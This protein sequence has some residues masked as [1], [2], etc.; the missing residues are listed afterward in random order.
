MRGNASMLAAVVIGVSFLFVPQVHATKVIVEK[1]AVQPPPGEPLVYQRVDTEALAALGATI[2]AEYPFYYLADVPPDSLGTFLNSAAAR[3]FVISSRES[4]DEIRI[5]GYAFPS[6][7]PLPKLPP[8]LTLADYAGS[9][10]LYLVQLVGPN[11]DDWERTLRAITTPILYYADNTYVLRADPKRLADLRAL[12]FLQHV[13]VFQ[14]A[15]KVRPDVLAAD[16]PV[17]VVVQL[18]GGQD[19]SG[20]T[21]ILTSLA[22]REVD[23]EP[24]GPIRNV[25]LTL[26]AGDATTLSFLPEVVWI[27]RLWPGEP[28]DERQALVVAGQHNGFQPINPATYTNWL[29]AK[30]FCT[31]GSSPPGCWSYD[32]RVAVFDSGFDIH[33]CGSDGSACPGGTE[34]PD[35]IP[36]EDRFFCATTEP[37]VCPE[38]WLTSNCCYN[39]SQYVNTDG[40][41]HGTAVA[42]VIAGDTSTGRRSAGLDQEGFY[43]GSGVA[44]SARLVSFRIWG[45]DCHDFFYVDDYTP[46]P[47]YSPSMFERYS[48]RLVTTLGVG[49]VR[50]ANHSW[51]LPEL[52]VENF[53][54]SAYSQKFDQLVRDA[55]GAFDQFDRPNSIIFSAG[56]RFGGGSKAVL[57]PANAKNVIA[58]GALSSWR[59]VDYPVMPPW[60]SG[61]CGTA[62]EIVDVAHYSRRGVSPDLTRF[63]PDIVAP[64]T[65]V[66]GA[67]TMA[68]TKA[69]GCFDTSANVNQDYYVRTTGTSFAAPVV[70]G[71]AVLAERWYQ[72]KTGLNPVSPAMVKAMLVAHAEDLYYLNG[73]TKVWGTDLMDGAALSYR[74]Q[75][76][77]G[78][79]R[80]NLDRLFQSSVGVRFFDEDHGLTPV[81]RF[82]AGAGSWSI[83]LQVANSS[84]D[85]IVVM[86]FTD[87]PASVGASPLKVNDLDLVIRNGSY[88][89]SGNYFDSSGY[90]V[91][92]PLGLLFRDPNNNVE[93]VRIRPGE[94]AG[95]SFTLEVQPTAVS[96][97]AVPGLDGPSANQD[98]ALYVYN[99]Q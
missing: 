70:T 48:Q 60:N 37:V 23:Y 53:N 66:G 55:D 71:A 47:F 17:P 78:W 99:V 14:P 79:G 96:A 4:F 41:A 8:G 82:T 39:G 46:D 1:P 81:R 38:Y 25:S 9:T 57:A 20:V 73:Q 90:S 86:A 72:A 92:I 26:T 54:Y 43:L 7:G 36:R 98:F 6:S 10:G 22:D 76:P 80:I 63:K 61:T 77:Q 34:H 31:P 97:K 33:V 15:Y 18:D 49:S 24:S 93:M 84:K 62:N 42:S 83:G 52:P 12:P 13:S 67:F 91:R 44:P 3:G 88:N 58:V 35:L 75:K 56:N 40:C 74:P 89:Y 11:R 2:L 87:A 51:N 45:S 32:T 16:G 21:A 85:V 64:A 94:I 65:R 19:L 50:F 68:R 28:S 30:G 5:N 59:P 27:E 95:G 69:M 29:L